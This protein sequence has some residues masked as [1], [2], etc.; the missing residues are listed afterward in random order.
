MQRRG[1]FEAI[2]ALLC[3][4]WNM[5]RGKA[6]GIYQ[7][8]PVENIPL[9]DHL[10]VNPYWSIDL[11][12]IKK[13]ISGGMS[14]RKAARS[15]WGEPQGTDCMSVCLSHEGPEFYIAMIYKHGRFSWWEDPSS[16]KIYRIEYFKGPSQRYDF[17]VETEEFGW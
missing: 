1:F 13:L 12:R 6:T 2:A 16:G 4:P 7:V 14:P 15:V 17:L 3:W 5:A 8:Y 10:D 9:L 11:V